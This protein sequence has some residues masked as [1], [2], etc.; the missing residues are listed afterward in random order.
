MA[1]KGLT[2]P[3]HYLQLSLH[4]IQSS[5][6]I[7]WKGIQK[8][9]GDAANVNRA[10]QWKHGRGRNENKNKTEVKRNRA[11]AKVSQFRLSD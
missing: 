5:G 3:E 1:A 7:I 9:K 11:E 2:Q 4:V 8:Q 6:L 10:V